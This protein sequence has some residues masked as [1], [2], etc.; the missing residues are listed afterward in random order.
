[1]TEPV[2]IASDPSSDL[3]VAVIGWLEDALDCE[4]RH[5]E[6]F[7]SRR[8]GWLVDLDCADGRSLQGFLRLE[9]FANGKLREAAR[10]KK[11]RFQH[12][13]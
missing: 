10:K 5:R 13:R 1:M 3:P 6:R 7:V 12:H 4:V 8:E 2:S 9:R 11:Q